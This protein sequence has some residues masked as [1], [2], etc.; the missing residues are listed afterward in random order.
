MEKEALKQALTE[1]HEEGVFHIGCPWLGTPP[2][3]ITAL[4]GLDPLPEGATKM[5][6]WTWKMVSDFGS[7]I[8]KCIA[9]G[10]FLVLVVLLLLGVFGTGRVITAAVNYWSGK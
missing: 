7:K 8:G 6:N 9:T 2:D 3:R 4:K 5:V 1:L 10:M